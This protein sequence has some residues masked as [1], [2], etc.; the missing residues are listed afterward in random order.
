VKEQQRATGFASAP[1]CA[2]GCS[3]S[4]RCHIRPRTRSHGQSGKGRSPSPRAEAVARRPTVESASASYSLGSTSAAAHARRVRRFWSA[5]T[6]RLPSSVGGGRE[7]VSV[8]TSCSARRG[9]APPRVGA[10]SWG[11]G[12]SAVAAVA[13]GIHG[14]LLLPP[15][16]AHTRKAPSPTQA[17]EGARWSSY[18]PRHPRCAGGLGEVGGEQGSA[19]VGGEGEKKRRV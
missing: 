14:R 15:P 17:G 19:R 7:K 11:V 2:P 13:R 4:S 5:S 12:G 16:G 3:C 6:W 9:G 1:A 8:A 10:R 18:V